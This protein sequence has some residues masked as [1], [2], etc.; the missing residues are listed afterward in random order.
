MAEEGLGKKTATWLKALETYRSSTRSKRHPVGTRDSG[1]L[2]IDMQRYFLDRD[3]HAYLTGSGAVIR[4]V[5]ALIGRFRALDLPVIFTRHA[6]GKQEDE[7]IMGTW[8]G[9]TLREDDVLSQIVDDL[10]PVASEVVLRKTRYSAFIGTDLE[11]ILRSNGVKRLF[12]TGVMT[13]L[14]CE[15]T[16]REAFMR[17]FEVFFVVDGTSSGDDDLHL[18]SLKCLT[19]GFAI[20]VTTEEVLRCPNR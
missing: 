10:R 18:S 8:W 19:D 16:A 15:S 14:C 5:G 17:D 12:V 4:N 13:H 1:L 3:S 20:P 11:Q 6:L 7:G 9:D 2:V